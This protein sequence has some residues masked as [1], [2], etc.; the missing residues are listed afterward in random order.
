MDRLNNFSSIDTGVITETAKKYGTPVYLY[1]EKMIVDRCKNLAAMPNAYG[2]EVGFAMKANSNKR[3]LKIIHGQGLLIDASSLNEARRAHMAGVPCADIML[4]TQEVPQGE[5]RADLEKMTLDGLRYNVCSLRQLELIG[6]F[7]AEH[8]I[9]LSMRVHPGVGAGETATRNTGDNYSCFGVHLSDIQNAM[10]YAAQKKLVFYKVH[11]HIGSGGD[12]A[13]WRDNIRHEL[14]ILEKYFPDADTISFGGGLKEARMPDETAAD[15]Q[16]LGQY[17]KQQIEEFYKRTGRKLK[18]EIEPGTYI[19]AN[20]GYII[21]QVIDK[22]RTGDDGLNFIVLDGGMEVNARPLLYG[23]RHP[24]YVVSQNG[25]LLSSEYA[26]A[27]AKAGYKAAVVGRCCES[28]DSQTLD[29]AG[30]NLPRQIAEPDAGD[31]VVIGGTGGYCSSMAPFNYNS[32]LQAAEVLFTAQ[33]QLE[34]I[35][36]KQSFAQMVENEI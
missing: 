28:G 12:P 36:R 9:R 27:P 15:I 13:A 2:L 3:L 4:T 30:L 33:N 17:A 8:N 21:T 14:D 11:V 7:A 18:M 32:H 34:L 23:S 24:F 19:V 10:D 6:S 31:Y 29:A 16:E 1:D 22:K 35:R 20:A 25:R 26:D 5:D